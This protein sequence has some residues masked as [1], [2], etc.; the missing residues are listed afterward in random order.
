L[1]HSL[2]PD[3]TWLKNRYRNL[4]NFR[5]ITC[6]FAATRYFGEVDDLVYL[7]AKSN[8]HNIAIGSFE[9]MIHPAFD[10]NRVLIDAVT[11]RS[12]D[13]YVRSI[14]GYANAVSYGQI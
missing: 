7:R 10:D 8:L 5:I 14:N 1:A 12:L 9:I 3:S 13:E 4:F 11:R 6:G 2:D